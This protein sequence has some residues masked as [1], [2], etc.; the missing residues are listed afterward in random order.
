MPN[1]GNN[2]KSNKKDLNKEPIDSRKKKKNNAFIG[3]P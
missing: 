2:T 3:E 1:K